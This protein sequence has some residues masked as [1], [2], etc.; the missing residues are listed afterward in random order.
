MSR[1]MARWFPKYDVEGGESPQ[2]QM[3]TQKEHH[4]V[5]E[6]RQPSFQ[7]R[8]AYLTHRPES[9]SPLIGTQSRLSSVSNSGKKPLTHFP[10]SPSSLDA[11][12]RDDLRTLIENSME[13]SEHLSG[14][15]GFSGV[16]LNG[17]GEV[18]KREEKRTVPDPKSISPVSSHAFLL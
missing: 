12:V 1:V 11:K 16:P 17:F 5:H 9:V 2:T 18:P 4:L 13:R 8:G 14:P 10:K 6:N 7:D 3:M 15:H